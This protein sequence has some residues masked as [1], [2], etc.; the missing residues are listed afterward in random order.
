MRWKGKLYEQ[1]VEKKQAGQKSLAV[2]IDPDKAH[3]RHLEL[4]TNACNQGE[5]D[6]IFVGGSLLVNPDTFADSI[7]TIRK[8]TSLPV[9]LFPGSPMQINSD[10]DAILLLS[11]ISGRNPELLI[12]HHVTAAP[13]LY[14]SG[15]EILSTGYMLVDGGRPSTVSYISGTLPLP[16]DKPEIAAATALAGEMIGMGIIYLDAG[17]GA[18]NPVPPAMIKAVTS[19]VKVPVVTGGGIRNLDDCLKAYEAGAD[20][21]VIGS[22][23]E[24]DPQVIRNI[25]RA[26]SSQK[27]ATV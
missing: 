24:N 14:N 26:K 1:L 10:A 4:V 18:L 15:L 9:I 21:V 22:A 11:L 16:A 13:Y 5:V 20:L 19:T 23:A 25:A 12:G 27:Q 3:D 6:Y 2:L 7:S 17:S 8:F